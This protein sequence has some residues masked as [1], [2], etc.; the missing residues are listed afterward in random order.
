MLRQKKGEPQGF[1]DMELVASD[2][3]IRAAMER[4]VLRQ[5]R[6]EDGGK[7]AE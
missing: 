3:K 2:A 6:R 1:V 4:D 5:S 7:E